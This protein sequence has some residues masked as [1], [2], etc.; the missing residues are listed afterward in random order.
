[1]YPAVAPKTASFIFSAQEKKR[2]LLVGLYGNDDWTTI[3]AFG[4]TN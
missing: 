2:D 4:C 1:M 3:P